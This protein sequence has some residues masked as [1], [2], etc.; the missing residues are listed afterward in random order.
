MSRSFS[1]A[2]QGQWLGQQTPAAVC[3]DSCDGPPAATELHMLISF[4]YVAFQRRTR[5]PGEGTGR[6]EGG[7][8]P[9]GTLLA[10]CL[11]APLAQQDARQAGFWPFCTLELFFG[12][13]AVRKP[14]ARDVDASQLREVRVPGLLLRIAG[15]PLHRNER[16]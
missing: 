6:E 14:A 12:L 8:L 16:T 4:D 7:C 1:A 10:R 13:K 2:R 5:L 15:C 9:L 11:L 3:H